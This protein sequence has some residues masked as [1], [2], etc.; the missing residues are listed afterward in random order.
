MAK[1]KRKQQ[2]LYHKLEK[3]GPR[4]AQQYL[5]SSI[6]TNRPLSRATVAKYTSAMERGQWTPSIIQFNSKDQLIDGQHRLH[7]VI[8]SGTTQEFL[9][10]RGNDNFHHIDVGKSRKPADV[11]AIM[12]YKNS[13]VLATLVRSVLAM[14]NGMCDWPGGSRGNVSMITADDIV[15]RLKKSPTTFQDIANKM[16]NPNAYGIARRLLRS[17]ATLGWF[18]YALEMSMD[19]DNEDVVKGFLDV[20]CGQQP[21]KADNPAMRLYRKL[22]TDDNHRL[23]REER[24]AFLIKAWNAYYSNE[25]IGRLFWRKFGRNAEAFPTLKTDF[26]T[27][28]AGNLPK[29]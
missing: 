8:R 2:S 14:E 24:A 15:Q 13:V 28:V 21:A 1:A 10:V 6:G 23:T 9:A 12:G 18:V 29:S 3:V 7:A 16:S 20:L 22:S 26:P 17:Y 27:A 25:S 19:V 11:L 4:K 5:E